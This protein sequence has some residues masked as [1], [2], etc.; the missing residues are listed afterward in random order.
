MNLTMLLEK[1]EAEAVEKSWLD[2]KREAMQPKQVSKADTNINK[3]C[4]LRSR[5]KE[6]RFELESN[7]QVELETKRNQE[8]AIALY[9]SNLTPAEK[10]ENYLHMQKMAVPYSS[11]CAEVSPTWRDEASIAFRNRKL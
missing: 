11:L 9:R 1:L 6:M 2:R 5:T 8:A 7:K 3:I 10:K 4:Q